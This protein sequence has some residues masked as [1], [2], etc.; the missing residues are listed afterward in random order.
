MLNSMLP[1]WCPRF[2]FM[3]PFSMLPNSI[4]PATHQNK[5]SDLE[6]YKRHVQPHA[7]QIFFCYECWKPSVQNCFYNISE[8]KNCSN[9]RDVINGRTQM[10]FEV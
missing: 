7:I 10:L 2:F 9:L 8:V 5:T 4:V 1:F 3:I 6:I